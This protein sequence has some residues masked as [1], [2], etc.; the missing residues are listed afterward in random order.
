MNSEAVLLQVVLQLIVI[1]ICARAGGK[2]FKCL[3]QPQV[4]GEIATGMLLGPSFFGRLNPELSVHVFPDQTS[5]V[6][7]VLGQL[8]L[9]FL[10][11]IVGLEFDFGHL[12]S[13]GRTAAGVAIAGIALPFVLGGGLAY[14]I[15][16]SVAAEHDMLGFVLFMATA[17]S[18][19]A[20]P[21]L[22]RIMMELGITQT[23]VG[24]LTISA[25]AVDDAIGW[26]LLAAVSAGVHGSFSLFPVMQMLLWTVLFIA[27][28][29]FVVRPVVCRWTSGVLSKP[30]RR[31]PV[32]AFAIVLLLVLASALVTNWIGIFSIFGPFVL[33]ASLC[34][35][36]ALQ[37]AI[38]TR[39]EEFVTVFFLPVFFT[40]TGLRTNMGALDS[41][42]LWGVCGLVVAVAIAGKVVGCGVAARLGG[43][44]WRDSASVAV[45]MNTRALM[46][47]IAVNI[48]R[49]LGVIPDTIF[50]MMVMMAI[51]TTLMTAPL[52][53]RLLRDDASLLAVK[54]S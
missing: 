16:S 28:V 43:F 48:G 25:A 54:Q 30:D 17:I 2:V 9:I 12:R 3:G 31:L 10:M 20:I 38:R 39:L 32:S 26:V 19:T 44:S 49:D 13:I 41:P 15:H 34:D 42:Y 29:F 47:L 36:H 24:V 11:F 53:R 8:G 18:I 23:P 21:V 33:G 5:Q 1:I 40:Y 27:V 35:Q 37:A 52:L 7:M 46:G 45:M 6:F 4:V 51:V 50:C 22:G 14:G